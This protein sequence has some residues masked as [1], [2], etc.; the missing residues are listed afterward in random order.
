MVDFANLQWPAQMLVD[1]VRVYQRPEGR[2][3]CDPPDRPT[4]A[5]IARH[6]E[7]YTN[8]NLTT[9]AAAGNTFPVSPTLLVME[10]YLSTS[11]SSM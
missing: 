2:I 4:A 10:W 5:Y 3:G 11:M 6:N 1:Y 7:A 9:W 8:P